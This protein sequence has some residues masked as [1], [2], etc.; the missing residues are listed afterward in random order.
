MT[1]RHPYVTPEISEIGSLRDI[2][3]IIVLGACVNVFNPVT[4]QIDID[5]TCSAGS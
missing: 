4:L 5:N 1:E 3:Q 2:T